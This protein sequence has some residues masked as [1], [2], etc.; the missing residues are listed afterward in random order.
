[1]AMTNAERQR[2]YRQKSKA[3]ASGD[4]VADQ[5]RGA[6][7]RAIDASWAYHERPAPSGSRWSDIDG[8]T[9]SAEYR[10]ESEDAQGASLTACR[11]FSPDF[12]GSSREEAIAVSAVIEIAEIIGAIPPQPRTLPEEP[13]PE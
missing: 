11:A 1:M 9:T 2:R 5:V 8:C 4:A 7:D 13:S 3:R 12:D 10:S 6:M